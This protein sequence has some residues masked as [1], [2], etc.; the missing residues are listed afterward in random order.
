VCDS[1]CYIDASEESC[2]TMISEANVRA[3]D[4]M[5]GQTLL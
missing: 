5:C 3:I 4:F 2:D 1:A